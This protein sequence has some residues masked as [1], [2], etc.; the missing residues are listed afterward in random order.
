[1]PC[2][3]HPTLTCHKT[4]PYFLLF[5]FMKEILMSTSCTLSWLHFL[6]PFLGI[7]HCFMDAL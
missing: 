2:T 5:L 4:L 1:M 6:F 7:P 3:Q